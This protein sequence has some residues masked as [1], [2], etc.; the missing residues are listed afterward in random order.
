MAIN[1][2]LF[3]YQDSRW[4]DIYLCL[5]EHGFDVYSPGQK[6]GECTEPYVVVKNDGGYKHITY[7]SLREQYA[8]YI[9]VPKMRY[10]LL[11]PMVMAV[12]EAMK[13]LYPMLIDYGQMQPSYYDDQVKAHSQIIE[14]ENYKKL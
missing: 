4:K 12:R 10:S 2:E 7:S 11:E 6:E 8:I 9:F 5:K 1:P 13:D 3:Q 14:Y